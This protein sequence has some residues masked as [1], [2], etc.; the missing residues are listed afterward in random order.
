MA[1]LISLN[2]HRVGEQVKYDALLLSVVDLFGT[3]WELRLRATVYD[4][5]IGSQA[6]GA[7]GGV[8]GHVAAAHHSHLLAVEDGCLGIGLICLHQVDTGQVLIGGVHTHQGLSR[9]L[10]KHRQSGAGA[11]KNS[12]IAHVE[13]FRN[14][15][16]LAD[17]HI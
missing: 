7:P 14:G 4:M 5:D 6:L 11:D 2:G 16:Y 8:H 12:L 3:G 9:D 10:H 13:Q 1:L 17:H 15:Q